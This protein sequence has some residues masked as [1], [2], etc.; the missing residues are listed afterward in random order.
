MSLQAIS[1]DGAACCA[2]TGLA[3]TGV[4]ATAL[5]WLAAWFVRP[6][7]TGLAR[8]SRLVGACVPALLAVR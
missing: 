4:C 3:G 5:V 8:V 6:R 1:L 2:G 7:L